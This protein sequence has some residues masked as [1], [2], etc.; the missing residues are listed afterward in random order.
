MKRLNEILERMT[1]VRSELLE[2]SEVEEP[3]EEQ[4]SRF[5]EL[6][7]EFDTLET[8]RAPLAAKADKIEAIRSAALDPRNVEDGFGGRNLNI[9]AD[10]FENLE[11]LRYAAPGDENIRARAITALTDVHYRGVK[12]S[13][14]ERAV[15]LVETIPGA[16]AYALAHG[17]P[18][19]RSAFGTY[20]R[21]HGE[22][23]LY[24]PQESEALRAA[25]SL[26]TTTGGFALPTLLDPTLIHTGTAT[27]NP[28]RA[29]SRVVTGT[30]NV[31]HG[32][33][34]GNVTTYWKAEGSAMTEG[35][36]TYAGPTVTAAALTA[37]L[38][39][40]YEIFEDSDLQS[41]LPGL[42]GEAFDFAEGTA[43]VL[44]SGST[45]PKGV[46]TAISAT[47]GSTVTATTRGSF[48]TASAV[49]VFAVVNAIPSRYEASASWVANKAIFNVIRQMSATGGAGSLFWTNFN[50]DA[51]G[52]QPLLG[53]P[54]VQASDMATAQTSGTILAILG[55]FSQFLIYDR[56]GTSV[57]FMQNVVDGSG[58]PTGQRGLVA[59][60]RVGSDVTDINAFRFLK[61]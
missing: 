7:T 46:V 2:L 48:T 27:K 17:S 36:P 3:T 50:N 31:W 58:L 32:V 8:E 38:T 59:H 20:M 24:N 54:I 60:K 52:A 45:A 33:S 4:S 40:S 39:A 29:I 16:G 26:T 61:T 10:P 49:D 37:Y 57:E 55:D 5:T 22:H 35:S 15:E 14:I 21:A 19:Y 43:F 53:S 18:A 9:K 30:Q 56:I 44:G 1:S 12:D 23:P 41:Q 34:V 42:I 47:A 13:Q 51:L 6:E 28:L 25:M 11:Q